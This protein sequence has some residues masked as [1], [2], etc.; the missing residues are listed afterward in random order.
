VQ[1]GLEEIV[2]ALVDA[3]ADA[4]ARDAKGNT[5]I[6]YAAEA[7]RPDIVKLLKPGGTKGE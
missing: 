6:D 3:K 5:P 4:N 7:G 1:A 2:A